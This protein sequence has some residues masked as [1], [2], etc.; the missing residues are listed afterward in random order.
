MR[1][2]FLKNFLNT[3]L[4]ENYIVNLPKHIFWVKM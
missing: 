1:I 2:E 4:L 3:F